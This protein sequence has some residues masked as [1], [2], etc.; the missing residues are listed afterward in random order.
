MQLEKGDSLAEGYTS[1][2]C[3]YTRISVMQNNLQEL[4]EIWDQW[5]EETKQLFYGSYG[6]LPYLL[7][8]KV[9]EH[10]FRAL[11]Q[12]WNLSYSC[13]TFRRVDLVPTV[14]EYT[15][16]LHCPKIQVD[17]A[18]SRA[19]YVPAFLKKL[20]NITGMMHLDTKKRIDVFALSIYGLMIF[21]R[22]L[23]YV[24]EAVSDLLDRLD[25]GVTTVPAILAETFRSLNACRRASEGRFIGCVQL[26]LAWFHSDDEIILVES[27]DLNSL[28]AVISS[29]LAQ[30]YVRKGCEA[31]FAYVLDSKVVERKN[32]SVPVV[33]E[34]PDVFP[35]EFLGLPPIRE[36]EFDIELMSETTLIPIAPYRMALTELKELKA[37]LQELTDKSFA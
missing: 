32:E 9:D 8:I 5:D 26:L 17:K 2:L 10:L 34:Y 20:M 27:N 28:P 1:E 15:A 14:E 35:K 22:V 21:P 16:L 13:F 3:D 6:D 24:D 11:T 36:V 7:D 29:M 31:Y 33:C 25:K 30:K 23:R 4:K 18:Y 19:T 12:Y 37:Q